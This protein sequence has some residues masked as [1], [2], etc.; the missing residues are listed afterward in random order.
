MDQP[1]SVKDGVT[2]LRADTPLKL[3]EHAH[4]V[5]MDDQIVVADMRSGHYFGLD[6]IGARAWELIGE[7]L[8]C[9]A[10]VERLYSEY[11]VPM[12]V[13]KRDVEELL[14][15]LLQRRLAENVENSQ[16]EARWWTRMLV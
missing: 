12:H 16:C 7:H 13:L 15:D 1:G 5:R 9:D 3:S 11:D 2:E 14:R 6:G 10:I 8:G 4:Y